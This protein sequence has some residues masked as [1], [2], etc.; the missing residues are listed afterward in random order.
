[1]RVRTQFYTLIFSPY[2]RYYVPCIVRSGDNDT[3][4][5]MATAR[6]CVVLIAMNVPTLYSDWPSHYVIPLL[7]RRLTIVRQRERY[8]EG[9]SYVRANRSNKLVYLYRYCFL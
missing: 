6:G 9:C 3:W 2:Y 1:M 4:L 5:L 7:K 8:E